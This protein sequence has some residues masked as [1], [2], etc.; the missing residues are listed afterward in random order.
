MKTT[1]TTITLFLM[2]NFLFSQTIQ[3]GDYGFGLKLAFDQKTKKLTGYFENYTGWNEKT[4]KPNFSCI[5]Y[6]EGQVVNNKFDVL[7]YYPEDKTEDTIK[8]EIEIVG[9][10]AIK[11]KLSSEHGGCW[12]VQ[13]F[14][15]EPVSFKM[16]KKTEW[17]QIK[18]V[19]TNKAYFYSEKSENK[20]L[21][22]YLVKNDFVSIDRIEGNWAYC[23]FYGNRI[24]KGWIKVTDLN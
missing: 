11:I 9:E 13:N 16:E 23:T 20:K 2:S 7:T 24:T 1:L 21:K 17:K 19:V 12:N 22:A 3:S 6:V 14:A 8:G 18:Y 5:F 10:N 4:N 15:D